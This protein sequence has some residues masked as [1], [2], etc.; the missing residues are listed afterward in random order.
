[1][2]ILIRMHGQRAIVIVHLGHGYA[3]IDLETVGPRL[4][5]D[6]TFWCDEDQAKTLAGGKLE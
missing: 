4:S 1:M 5:H 6:E 3:W 2:Y